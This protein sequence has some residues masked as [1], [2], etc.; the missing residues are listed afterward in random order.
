MHNKSHITLPIVF[1]AIAQ[2]LHAQGPL[3]GYMKGRGNLDL[4]PS[5]SYMHAPDFAG[6]NNVRYDEPY[7]GYMLSLFAEYGITDRFDVVATVPYIITSGQ[8]GLQDGGFYAKY[9]ILKTKAGQQGQIRF[10]GGLGASF[11][12]SGYEPVAASA[13]GQRAVAVPARGILQWDTKWGPFVNLTGGY[14]WRLDDYNSDD[15]ERI[16]DLRP[17]YDPAPP[18][19]YGTWMLKVGLPAKNYYLDAWYEYQF[20]PSNKGNDYVQGIVD[21]PQAYGVSYS[22]VGGTLYYSENG[23]RGVCLSAAKILDG[24][25]VSRVFRLTGGFVVKL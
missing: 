8:K 4:A 12:L 20:T 7:T 24:R 18:P 2:A 3:D 5:F 23:K 1:F 11:P 17:E 22:Q 13:L 10:I 25:N 19:G 14:N 15:L 9:Q 6:A 16:Q 21:L